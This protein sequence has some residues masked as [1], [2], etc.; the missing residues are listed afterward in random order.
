MPRTITTPPAE[1]ESR[2]LRVGEAIRLTGTVFTGRDAFH[3]YAATCPAGQLPF[4]PA[5][6]VLFHC[7]PIV[8]REG[9]EW[10]LTAAGPTTSARTEPYLP[11]LIAVH[12]VRGVIGKG[13]MGETARAAFQNHG[14]VYFS[15]PGGCAQLLAAAVQ[16]VRAV[17]FLE[18]FGPPEA[19]WELEVAD[20]PLLVTMDAHGGDLHRD[21]AEQS[22]RRCAALCATAIPVR[23]S[24]N[25]QAFSAPTG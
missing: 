12:G 22:R 24:F 5:G 23:P 14:C 19:V 17:H 10:R 20:L 1:T 6:A 15:A 18:Q 7:G 3:R 21:L 13:G 11:T 2:S 25:P 9:T 8:V 4:A 16:C